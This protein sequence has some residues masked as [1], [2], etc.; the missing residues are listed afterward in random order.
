MEQKKTFEEKQAELEKI[1][2]QL[3]QDK[4]L[5]LD[6]TADLYSKGKKLILELNEELK[7]LKASVSNEIILDK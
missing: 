7:N 3:D 2:E 5:T 6:E 4:E 1:I